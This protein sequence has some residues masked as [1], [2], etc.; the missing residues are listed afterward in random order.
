[1]LAAPPTGAI[2][3]QSNMVSFVRTAEGSCEV[4]NCELVLHDVEARSR[5]LPDNV[6]DRERGP[7]LDV[8]GGKNTRLPVAVS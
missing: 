6:V 5:L 4:F 3:A 8:L 1:M 2:A 7:P